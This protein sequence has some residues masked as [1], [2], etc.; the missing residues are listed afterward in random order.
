[1]HNPSPRPPATTLK[2][3]A[4]RPPAGRR[5]RSAMAHILRGACYGL[6]T[7]LIGLAFVLLERLL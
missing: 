5:R 1:M 3:P 6:G 7:G 2:P 4:S